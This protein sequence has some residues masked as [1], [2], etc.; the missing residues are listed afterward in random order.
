MA[1]I[2]IADAITPMTVLRGAFRLIR[3]RGAEQPA[4]CDNPSARITDARA[5]EAFSL[6]S[7]EQLSDIGVSRKLRRVK[8]DLFDRSFPPECMP[9]FD[10]FRLGD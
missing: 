7:E 10:Y 6:F 5:L 9:V 8:W 3:H 2:R 4:S 1:Y